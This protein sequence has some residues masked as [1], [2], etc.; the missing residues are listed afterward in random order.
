MPLGNSTEEPGETSSK[1]GGWRQR[2]ADTLIPTW[3]SVPLILL[4]SLFVVYKPAGASWIL[5]GLALGVAVLGALRLRR[6]YHHFV[7]H[8]EASGLLVWIARG[9]AARTAQPP[10]VTL[11]GRPLAYP[12]APSGD[13]APDPEV[14][15]EQDATPPPPITPPEAVVADVRPVPFPRPGESLPPRTP[16]R[17]EEPAEAPDEPAPSD[18][19]P[20]MK[21][22]PDCAE[23]VLAA[24]KVCRYCHYRFDQAPDPEMPLGA[25]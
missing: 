22:C 17:V 18:G 15:P 11:R 6:R 9:Q 1:S 4:G 12:E 19:T 20:A 21:V 23:K 10:A 25:P 5:Y 13:D 7:L 14:S 2:L 24:A 16:A 8:R 3:L